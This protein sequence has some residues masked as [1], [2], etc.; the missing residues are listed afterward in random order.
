MS[1]L[2]LS[3]S[4]FGI[5]RGIQYDGLP[6]LQVIRSTIVVPDQEAEFLL[7]GVV[8]RNSSDM[9]PGQ[10][11]GTFD[12][13]LMP[14]EANTE[15]SSIKDAA[16]LELLQ[17]RLSSEVLLSNCTLLS[18]SGYEQQLPGRAPLLLNQLRLWLPQL[19][20]ARDPDTVAEWGMGGLA[21]ASGLQPALT[22]LASCGSRLG[23]NP[24]RLIWGP[25]DDHS[26][27][28]LNSS[29]VSYST[30]IIPANIGDELLTSAADSC[31]VDGGPTYNSNPELQ[32][33]L[34]GGGRGRVFSDL[35]GAIGRFA[36]ARP[37]TLRN[38]VLYNLAPGGAYPSDDQAAAAAAASGGGVQLS[39][40][41]LNPSDA[42]WENSS[43]PLWLFNMSRSYP[44]DP[45]YQQRPLPPEAA[46]LVLEN[47]TL[48][49]S[50]R[51]WRALVAALLLVR[52]TKAL[53]EAQQGR[54]SHQPPA[55]K[56]LEEQQP[57]HPWLPPPPSYPPTPPPA[58]SQPPS[59]PSPAPPYTATTREA[60]LRYAAASQVMSLK[61]DTGD[62]VLA[63]AHHYGWSGINVTI[64]YQLPPD[65]PSSAKLLPYPDLLLPYDD[66]ADTAIDLRREFPTF[67]EGPPQPLAN[68][69]ESPPS[70]SPANFP[71][72][73][74][75]PSS[76]SPP[77]SASP[78][79]SA[80]DPSSAPLPASASPPSSSTPPPASAPSPRGSRPSWQA[81]LAASLSAVAGAALLGLLATGAVLAARRRGRG[82]NYGSEPSLCSMADGGS[83][84]GVE[85]KGSEVAV[86]CCSKESQQLA[87]GQG[88]GGG[89]G[90]GPPSSMEEVTENAAGSLDTQPQQR[91][92]VVPPSSN[93]GGSH[94]TRPRGGSACLAEV[95]HSAMVRALIGASSS[96][97]DS[98]A[99]SV[100]VECATAAGRRTAVGDEHTS[101][102]GGR[103]GLGNDAAVIQNGVS[104]V[105]DKSCMAE[106]GGKP[107]GV[108]DLDQRIFAQ[109]LSSYFRESRF[110]PQHT[111][112]G[113]QAA[114]KDTDRA[115]GTTPANIPNSSNPNDEVPAAIQAIQAELRDPDLRL[116]GSIG[117][118]SFG[119]VYRGL[120]RGLPVAVKTLVVPQ[121]AAV[122][123]TREGRVQQRA[124]LEAAISMAM[125]HP[126]VVATYSFDIK[127]LTERVEEN[128]RP[129]RDMDIADNIQQHCDAVKLYIVQEYCNG[130]TIRDLLDRGLAG[131][132]RAGGLPGLLA[133]H[134]ALNVARGME[135]IH[136]CRIVHGDL[137]PDNV[138]IVYDCVPSGD[139]QPA[140]IMQTGDGLS[141][142]V[143]ASSSSVQL[144][145]KVADFGLSVRMPE[146]ATH[147]SRHFHGTPSYLAPE[148]AMAGELSPRADVWS[149]GLM[150]IELY[151][152]CCLKEIHTA[153]AAVHGSPDPLGRPQKPVWAY[154]KNVLAAITN[155]PFAELV[156]SCLT[157][158]PRDRPTFTE[159]AC[160]LQNMCATCD[161]AG[162]AHPF[163]FV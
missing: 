68:V 122:G 42:A 52:A 114:A 94:M 53:P 51:E 109:E 38:L 57:Q 6:Q 58:T 28:P 67:D 2:A 98:V 125:S 145:A 27:P 54:I 16:W 40:P 156:S 131:S 128:D 115:K 83:H 113:R 160:A 80:L 120:W 71:S 119:V 18:A 161:G 118:G 132:V 147:V 5:V 34:P 162:A 77:I 86:V 70:T 139:K 92:V 127:P 104:E 75:A 121:S 146:D 158:E 96:R 59:P 112:A 143:A 8:G 87:D 136:S 111:A 108:T 25:A 105:E 50:E 151:F 43:L 21:V 135:H 72:S 74:L 84:Q 89:G 101:A 81:P 140:G 45:G 149:F 142:T 49:V 116:M 73:A 4:S 61:Y 106:D 107:S 55:R 163:S 97:A 137:K 100:G 36:L 47:V 144:T 65:A 19:L 46:L 39:P 23:H 150:L 56:M 133:L 90:G 44:D 110:D 1:L 60:L 102:G 14:D 7:A 159:I 130:G 33:I 117:S 155:T 26:I 153:C 12:I 9:W 20:A 35:Q 126:N 88:G 91:Q 69:T 63:V 15:P 32:P 22:S 76:A 157:Q 66:L 138:L 123:N 154:F 103:G 152:G 129:C 30:T 17:L 31:I 13:A 3:F 11:L 82:R 85:R 62:L 41:P 24:I 37:I 29:L 78:P 99:P 93:Q 10:P 48:V 79:S 148:V 95:I 124:V 134:L 141:S 64:K